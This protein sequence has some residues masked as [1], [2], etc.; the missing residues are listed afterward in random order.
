MTYWQQLLDNVTGKCGACGL[1]PSFESELRAAVNKLSAGIASPILSNVIRDMEASI[2][3]D[4]TGCCSRFSDVAISALRSEIEAAPRKETDF[5][6]PDH[7]PDVPTFSV[8]AIVGVF[9]TSIS[10][11][12]TAIKAVGD[13]IVDWGD[14]TRYDVAS[15]EIADIRG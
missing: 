9:D 1:P 4:P 10:G 14:D 13:Y 3:N 2:I 7:W 15:G 12:S 6:R 11:R 5:A 8:P